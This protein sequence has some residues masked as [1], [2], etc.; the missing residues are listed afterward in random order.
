MKSPI[1]AKKGENANVHWLKEQMNPYFFI[2][3]K[4]EPGALTLLEKGL[5]TLRENRRLILADRDKTFIMAMVNAPGTLYDSLRRF[6]E[7]DISYAMFTHSHG[8]MPGMEQALEIQR[9]E[10]DR[11]SNEEIV[12]GRNVEVPSP[13][14]RK[15]VSELK[16]RFPAFDLKDLDRLLRILWLNNENY[17]RISPPIRVA[18]IL[19]LLQRGNQQGGLYLGLEQLP[20]GRESRIL[21][22]VGNPPQKDF[23]FQ[24][25]E[26]FNR[27][28]LAVNR[29][30]CLT[31]SNG[32]HPYFLGTFYVLHRDGE[33]LAKEDQVFTRLQQELYNTQILSTKSLLYRDLV[34][35]SL[36]NGED[37]SLISA[38][39]AFCHSSLSHNNPD[40]FDESEVKSAFHSHP[41]MALQLVRL[42]RTR[43]DPTGTTE[44]TYA[45]IL[46]DT[47]REV[48]EYNTGHKHFDEL[49]R[50]IFRSCLVFITHTLKTNF[51]V[52]EKQA[53]A[54]RLDPA[55]LAALGPEFTADLPQAIPF[56]ITFFFSRFGFG[57]HIG[58]SDIARGGWRTIIARSDD[59][60]RAAVSTLFREN[61]VLAHTQHLKN[62]DIYEGGS[63]LVMVLNV[64]DLSPREREMETWRLYKLQYGIINAFL[65]IFITDGG[66][67]SD[68]RV[69]DYYR[70]DEPI[71]IGPDE[72][73]HDSMIETIARL[74]AQRGY[75]LGIGIISSKKVGINHKEYGVTSTGVVRFAEITME[76]VG[77]CMGRDLFSVKFTGGPNGDVAGNAMRIMLDRCPRMSIRLILDGT[78]A[79]FDP[80]GADRNELSRIV[81]KKDLD[82]FDPAALH[83]GGF[84]LFRTG[85][86]KDGLKELYRKVRKTETGLAEEWIS[87]DEFHREFDSLPFT[88]EADLFIPAGGRPETIDRD[89]WQ[90]YFLDDGRPSSRVVIEGANSFLTPEARVQLQQKGVI[91][92]RD[93]SANK[94]GVISSSYEIIAN[95]LLTEQEF[96]EHKERYVSDVLQILEKRAADEARIILKRHREDPLLLYTEISDA[97]SSEINGHYAR[98]FR[99]FQSHP[100]LCLQPLFR[101]AIL[102]HLPRMLREEP[103]YRQRVKK[104]PQKYLFA[105]LAAEIG[106]SLVYEGDRDEAFADAIRLHLLRTLGHG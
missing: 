26:V 66:I 12:G 64:S 6:Q 18:R 28:S 31:V 100:E 84:M 45:T 65:D 37:A 80:S 53:L 7:R 83:Q 43:F 20:G 16:S 97:L 93:A 48:D 79:L 74:S 60:F 101:K 103:R 77:I 49:R 5:G 102:N 61:F 90:Q 52:L 50:T 94:C 73:M 78:A 89:N 59:D 22:A 42:F 15:I 54:F 9:F 36:M 98:L 62:K 99:Y 91:I 14:R 96:M 8:L 17:V 95:L 29:A 23:L 11:K 76:H 71:E 67:A 27:L 34:M 10:F 24:V 3:M 85:S 105:I 86:R 63:K 87:N 13:I 1:T 56:R 82:A 19:Q 47:K 88:V 21:F 46:A 106:S 57:Y 55:Y 44:A 58:F 75:M 81:L 2:S 33:P 25:M 41:E 51:F 38:F 30:Y 4:D 35:N 32:V 68:P 92:M 70:E 72:N 39:M 40:R 69:K 104:L